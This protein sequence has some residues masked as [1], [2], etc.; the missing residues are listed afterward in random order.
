MHSTTI[1]NRKIQHEL[2]KQV[3]SFSI[4]QKLP[5]TTHRKDQAVFTQNALERPL[6]SQPRHDLVLQ[7]NLRLQINQKQV[8]YFTI[9]KDKMS[10]LNNRSELISNCGYSKKFLLKSVLPQ[11][12]QSHPFLSFHQALLCSFK[13]CKFSYVSVIFS[14]CLIIA[15]QGA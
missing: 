10:T 11:L 2:L 6:L 5:S 1:R 15:S 14:S 3:Y 7:R 13:F 12:Y 4:T 9:C 8:K